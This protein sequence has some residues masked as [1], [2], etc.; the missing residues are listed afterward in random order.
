MEDQLQ[1][2]ESFQYPAA[3]VAHLND[4]QQKALEQFKKICEERG[5]YTAQ[6]KDGSKHS[7]HD[8]ET[9]L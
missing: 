8:D 4:K 7:S 9:M 6:P 5:Y 1:K 2:I 3:H